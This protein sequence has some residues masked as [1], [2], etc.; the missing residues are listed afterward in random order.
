MSN[1]ENKV[2]NNIE[3]TMEEK[4]QALDN[5]IFLFFM[6]ASEERVK[7]IEEWCDGK[8]DIEFMRENLKKKRAMLVRKILGHIFV[9]NDRLDSKSEKYNWTILRN[10]M[11]G[12]GKKEYKERMGE[13]YEIKSRENRIRS[14]A[15]DYYKLNKLSRAI[16]YEEFKQY[17]EKIVPIYRD[18]KNYMVIESCV[19]KDIQE[20]FAY[21]IM[22][23]M[24]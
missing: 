2:E 11:C 12:I 20:T 19:Q 16:E 10:V 4:V 7:E 17:I 23:A 8:F 5:L 15:W 24:I 9:G 1:P 6:D 22:A 21:S 18:E 3:M 13:E 14:V